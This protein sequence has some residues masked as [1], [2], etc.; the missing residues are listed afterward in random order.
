MEE[1]KATLDSLSHHGEND[2]PCKVCSGTKVVHVD[3]PDELKADPIY[4]QARFVNTCH[5]CQGSG[6]DWASRAV[7]ILG[8]EQVADMVSAFDLG[9]IKTVVQWHDL[10]SLL[11]LDDDIHPQRVIDYVNEMKSLYE[12]MDGD[13]AINARRRAIHAIIE[14]FQLDHLIPYRMI[15]RESEGLER[16]VRNLVLS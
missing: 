6:M 11:M 16:L 8:S 13:Q 5:T 2:T 1:M 15:T 4:K 3:C 14:A 10:L 12:F 7:L 9:T